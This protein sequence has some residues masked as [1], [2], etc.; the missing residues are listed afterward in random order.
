MDHRPLLSKIQRPTLVIAGRFDPTNPPDMN[1][2]ISERISGARYT[3]L[4]AG[5]IANVEAPRAYA[6]TVLEFLLG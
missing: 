1:S 2:F 4:E 3:V 5:H 6:E